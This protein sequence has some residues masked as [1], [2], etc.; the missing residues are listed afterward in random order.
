MFSY[1]RYIS[2]VNTIYCQNYGYILVV[3]PTVFYLYKK[4]YPSIQLYPLY[5]YRKDYPSIQLYPLYFYRK[6]YPSIQL[7]TLYFYRKD[8]PSIQLY[9][10]Y[11]YRKDYPSIQLYTLYFYRKDY[12]SIQLYTLNTRIIIALLSL[13]VLWMVLILYHTNYLNLWKNMIVS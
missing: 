9:T 11:F 1:R 6:D 4:D 2:Q 7:Y 13:T 10:L 12:R 8:Y 5:F 3:H